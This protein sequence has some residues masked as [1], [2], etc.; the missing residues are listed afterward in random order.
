MGRRNTFFCRNC[1]TIIILIIVFVVVVVMFQNR[2]VI[3][4]SLGC[5]WYSGGTPQNLNCGS[6]YF[7]WGKMGA[8]GGGWRVIVVLLFVTEDVCK[9]GIY[10]LGGELMLM[11]M[12]LRILFGVVVVVAVEVMV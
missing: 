8:D 12:K 11:L 2:Q 1:I 5:C 9:D 4:T 6:P 7:V 10:N 3:V